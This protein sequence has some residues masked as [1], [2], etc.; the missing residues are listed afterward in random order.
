[1]MAI[2]KQL[3]LLRRQL[4]ECVDRKVAAANG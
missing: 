1:V 3:W 2:K 4:Q